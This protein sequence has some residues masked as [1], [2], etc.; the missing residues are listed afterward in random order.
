MRGDDLFNSF[1]LAVA[2]LNLPGPVPT[3]KR[4]ACPCHPCN[5]AESSNVQFSRLC[6]LSI[7]FCSRP[8]LRACLLLSV[9]S[10]EHLDRPSFDRV[11]T[12]EMM[13]S[14][15]IQSTAGVMLKASLVVGLII[16]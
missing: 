16:S 4:S 2:L 3:V 11:L 12:A 5:V 9:K 13:S 14:G 15:H 6:G 7:L 10:K 8:M 1:W